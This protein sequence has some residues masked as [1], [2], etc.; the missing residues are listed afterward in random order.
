MTQ[1]AQPFV[2]GTYE[3]ESSGKL[4]AVKVQVTVDE[5]SITDL[6]VIE[7]N[8]NPIYAATAVEFLPAKIIET[9]S[10][11]VD[12]VSGA[13]LI[14]RGIIAATADALKAAG[15]SAKT[16]EPRE[17]PEV[18]QHMTP[19][20]YSAEA[21]GHWP[22]NSIDGVRFGATP[23][24]E[25][26]KVEVTV[27]ETSIKKVDVVRCTD[28]KEF[29]TPVLERV[30][31]AIVDEQSIFVDVVTGATATSA[32]IIKATADCLEQAGADMTGF[33]KTKPRKTD[34]MDVECD[35]CIVGGGHAGT[36]AALIAVEAGLDVLVLDK[37]GRIGGRGF[38]PSGVSAAGAQ[39]EKD[40]GI[41]LTPDDM[42]KQ[43]YSQSMGKAN[44]L[45]VRAIVE[46]SGEMIDF[47]VDHGFDV[48]PPKPGVKWDEQFMCE[49]GRGQEK[50]DHLYEDYICKLGGRVMLETRATD[51]VKE[52]G[53]IVG[54]EAVQQCGTKVHVKCKAA[55]VGTGGFGGS[56]EL[57]RRF[58]YSDAFYDR[59]LSTICSGDGIL[60]C[61]RAGA[62]LGPEIM[63]HMQEYAASQKCNFTA[64]LIKYITYAG[65]MDVNSE[66]K[67]FMDESLNTS[68]PMGYGCAALRVQGAYYLILDQE[69]IDI[70]QEKGIDGYYDGKTASFFD[71]SIAAR[72]LVPL[73]P[74][75][76]Q[77]AD[78]MA[79][80]EAWEGDTPEEL[81][82]A[83][84]FADPS[85]FVKTVERYNELCAKGVDEDFGKVPQMMTP[86]SGKMYAIRIVIPIMGTLG[87]VK[88][89]ERLEALD[90]SE[91]AIP[92]LYVCG[93]EGSGFYTYPYYSTRCATTTY[94]YCSG[95]I[96]GK[97]AV[98][99][100][101]SL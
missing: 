26:I 76:E 65:F 36:M 5:Q 41:E 30:P 99:Y 18:E 67:R 62:Q 70:L 88:V 63:P 98:E 14:S 4:G 57:L 27:D 33:L 49:H 45:L 19:G 89:N 37:A 6:K 10:L 1:Q 20:T 22:P 25:L 44:N 95:R 74:L 61:E 93:Q 64:N 91:K 85:I 60:M 72:A 68:D 38:C 24:P 77:L 40:A 52:D 66:G 9:Q 28:S 97:S 84:G 87:G 50:I 96:A 75:K 23:N 82:K 2:P 21:M 16:L 78:A 12:V 80:G 39:V 31:K 8:E 56:P 51:L 54:V 94:A 35:V 79:A 83:V 42:Y 15:G 73:P 69:K 43:L 59:G 11:K 92:G 53:R 34:E 47:L 32:A 100:V 7:N 86:Y 101:N 46:D 3:G 71:T 13:T 17:A 90:T 81:A 29:A 55:V 58:C 48:K